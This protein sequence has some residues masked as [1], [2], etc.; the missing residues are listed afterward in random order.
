MLKNGD[1]TGGVIKLEHHGSY[2]ASFTVT[3]DE[4]YEDHGVRNIRP[5]GC[6]AL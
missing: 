1:I 2:V 5:R 6:W 4:I 3:W